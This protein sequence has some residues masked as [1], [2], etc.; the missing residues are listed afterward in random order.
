MHPP[1][2]Q[3]LMHE[4]PPEVVATA[5]AVL[6]Y[7]VHYRVCTQQLSCTCC[8]GASCI[9]ALLVILPV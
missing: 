3:L 6:I 9:A 1:C 4:L 7:S 5:A 2:V 8:H